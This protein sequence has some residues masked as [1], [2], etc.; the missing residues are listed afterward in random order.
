LRSALDQ[1][2][3]AEL[4]IRSDSGAEAKYTFKHA[5]VQD[6]AYR[7]LL[8]SKRQAL[9]ARIVQA[10]EERFAETVETQPEILAH[11]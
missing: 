7:T 9:H 4:I 2:I 11:H 3:K 1:L 6:A 8:R 5:L 10:L